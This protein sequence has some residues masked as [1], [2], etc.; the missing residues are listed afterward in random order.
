MAVSCVLCL[1]A[2]AAGGCG[3]A[4]T[5]PHGKV[6]MNGEPF[7]PDP[8][9]TLQISFVGEGASSVSAVAQVNPDGTFTVPG[10]TNTGIPPGKYHVTVTTMAGGGPGGSSP[11]AGSAAPAGGDKFEG[12]YSDATKTP[13]TCEITSATPE[14]VIDVGKGTVSTGS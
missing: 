13:L 10:P 9:Q 4:G 5:K 8:G 14:I 11:P 6:V 12:K 2:L 7:K 1:A 3:G